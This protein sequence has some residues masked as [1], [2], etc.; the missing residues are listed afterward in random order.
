MDGDGGNAVK[1]N[2]PN[3]EKHH[4]FSHIELKKYESTKEKGMGVSKRGQE[5]VLGGEYDYSILYTCIT[6]SHWNP[7]FCI[8]NTCALFLNW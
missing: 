1:W 7:L 2:K 6:I 5:R 4:V 8:N 3:L